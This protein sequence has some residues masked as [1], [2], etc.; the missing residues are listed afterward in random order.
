MQPFLIVDALQ[1]L[2][3]AGVGFLEVAIFVAVVEWRGALQP[4]ALPEPDVNLSIHPAPIIGPL[5]PKPN[6]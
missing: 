6:G 2:A 4:R 3:D 5:V 1:E